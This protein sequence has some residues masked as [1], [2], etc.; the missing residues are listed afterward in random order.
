MGSPRTLSPHLDGA[1]TGSICLMELLWNSE[2]FGDLS[3][4]GEGLGG[5]L[6]LILVTSSSKHSSSSPY[7]KPGH[8]AHRCAYV[9]EAACA[10]P[11]RI[12]VSKKDLVLQILEMCALIADYSF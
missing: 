1:G 3:L 5:K 9:P 11:T 7:P 2:V 10:Q 12:R 4:P 6:W 8:M